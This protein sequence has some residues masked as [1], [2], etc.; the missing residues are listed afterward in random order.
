MLQD[1]IRLGRGSVRGQNGRG[2]SS[3]NLRLGES[4]GLFGKRIPA[5]DAAL[6]IRDDDRMRKL[7]K[8]KRI[9]SKRIW[10]QRLRLRPFD[11]RPE[12]RDGFL[13]GRY[14]E[15]PAQ[16]SR[17]A[18]IVVDRERRI[19]LCGIGLHHRAMSGFVEWIECQ[20]S[21][22]CTQTTFGMLAA[23]TQRQGRCKSTLRDLPEPLAFAQKPFVKSLLIQFAKRQKI[24]LIERFG[25]IERRYR[26]FDGQAGQLES[27][28]P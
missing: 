1:R 7:F 26:L 8:D 4:G 5:D 27:I 2:R 20:D 3:A 18:L 15:F 21:A 10:L 9:L 12:R 28:D 22:C 17:Q 24:S 16:I 13:F 11:D 23:S 25:A 14:A 19:P 6:E